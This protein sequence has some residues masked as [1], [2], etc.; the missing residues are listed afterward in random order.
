VLASPNVEVGSV[1][2]SGIQE[3]DVRNQI[4]GRNTAARNG[5]IDIRRRQK[6]HRKD[7]LVI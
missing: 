1:E 3:E 7:V 4:C 6:S 5:K 2:G